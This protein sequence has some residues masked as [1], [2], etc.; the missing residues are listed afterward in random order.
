M[1]HFPTYPPKKT[2]DHFVLPYKHGAYFKPR[3]LEEGMGWV[4]IGE[5]EW[6]A[7]HRQSGILVGKHTE[8]PEK[9]VG[10]VVG[11]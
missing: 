1:T 6:R 8:P 9:S 2:R 4:N 3:K 11:C 7:R 5:K 10:V